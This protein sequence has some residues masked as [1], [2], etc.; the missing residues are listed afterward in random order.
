MIN[1]KKIIAYCIYC[2]N[3]IYENEDFVVR[4]G[5][6]YHTKCYELIKDDSFGEDLSDYN[7]TE[8]EY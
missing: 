7:E 1:N 3:E 2:K 8:T 4:H 6:K 5:N